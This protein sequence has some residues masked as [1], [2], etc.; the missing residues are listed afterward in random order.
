MTRGAWHL[1]PINIVWRLS[2]GGDGAHQGVMQCQFC[3]TTRQ[4][5]TKP[6]LSGN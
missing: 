4:A 1:K 6:F 2:V 5:D 3:A